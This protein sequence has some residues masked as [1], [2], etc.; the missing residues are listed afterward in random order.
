MP[1]TRLALAALALAALGTSARAAEPRFK[2]HD[3][4]PT[5]PFEAAGV[6]DV[7][8][9]G[10]LDIVSGDT[11]YKGP[12]FKQASKV[13]DVV[14]VG[15]YYNCFSTIPMDVNADGR[16]DYVSCSYF[17]KNVGWVENPGVAG[18]EWTYHPIALPGASEAAVAVDLDGDGKRDIL[19]NTVNVVVWY[20]LERAG[21]EPVWKKHDFGAL[22]N[23]ANGHGVGTGDVNGDGRTD[24]LTPKGW[25]EAPADPKTE[26]W[27]WH[28]DWQLGAAGIQILARDVDGD[29]LSDVVYGMGHNYGLFWLKQGKGPGGER[30]WTKQTIDDSIASVHTL[31]WADLDGDGKAARARHGQEGL[32]PRGRA[33]RH[34]RVGRRLVRLRPRRGQVDPAR[35][36]PGRARQGRARQGGRS[37]RPEGLPRRHRRHRPGDDGRRHRPRRRHRPG[38]PRQERALPVREPR[39]RPLRARP[40]RARARPRVGRGD[41][42]R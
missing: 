24:L 10:T 22:S 32:R 39:R 13:R 12:D 2:K 14:R 15:T 5:S 7:D 40:S 16:M 20:S 38:L 17:G 27:T 37:R 1:A 11:W 33:R 36:L 19:P 35:D 34:R 9:D 6:F 23:K 8:G 29:G 26:T 21:P 42:L 18:K 30:S 25:F 3:I 28:P 41:P 4:N 31:L